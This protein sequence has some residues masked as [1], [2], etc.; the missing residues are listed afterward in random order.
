ME[1]VFILA[2]ASNSDVYVVS[3][4]EMPGLIAKE[5]NVSMSEINLKEKAPVG[6][7]KVLIDKF[8]TRTELLV[9]SA[10]LHGNP[11]SKMAEFAFPLIMSINFSSCK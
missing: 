6:H 1:K 3:V 2:T 11:A 7:Q 8:F 5:D 10:I 9:E 4:A